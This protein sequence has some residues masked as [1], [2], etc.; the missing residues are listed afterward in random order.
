MKDKRGVE[1]GHCKQCDCQEYTL[2]PGGHKCG[3]CSH[4]PAQH[5]KLDAADSKESTSVRIKS[6]PQSD[7]QDIMVKKEYDEDVTV[8]QGS[9]CT[10]PGCHLTADFDVN[11]GESSSFCLAHIGATPSLDPNGSGWPR[12]TRATPTYMYTCTSTGK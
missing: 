3:G 8:S 12:E 1:R 4:L 10:Y 11:T 2:S 5:V 7:S 9:R 6:E